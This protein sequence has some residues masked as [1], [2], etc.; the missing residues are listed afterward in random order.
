MSQKINA[1]KQLKLE[2]K[3]MHLIQNLLLDAA[4][5]LDNGE[6]VKGSNQE[7]AAYPSGLCAE[8]VAIFYAGSNY[9]NAKILKLLYY[10]FSK[11]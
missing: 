2:K 5:L 3:L 9:P 10:C 7:N 6:I 8:R 1:I 11:R 4:I